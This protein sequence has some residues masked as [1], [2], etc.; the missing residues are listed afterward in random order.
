MTL[1]DQYRALAHRLFAKS[2]DTAIDEL[3]APNYEGEYG[4]KTISGRDAFRASVIAL[5]N[6]LAPLDYTVHHTAE[7][8][9]LLWAHWTA[10]GT[11]SAR[12]FDLDPTH[13]PVAITGLTLNRFVDGKIVWGLVKWDRLALLDQL[14]TA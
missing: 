6:A 2:D 3:F 7:G 8:D 12:V 13:K 5:R 14:R 10:R 1:G 9:G 11:H 4:G